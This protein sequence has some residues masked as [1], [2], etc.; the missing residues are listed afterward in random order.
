MTTR[1]RLQ[2]L[3]LAALLSPALVRDQAI[4]NSATYPG[5][6]AAP[7]FGSVVINPNG[8]APCAVGST[9][10]TLPVSGGVTGTV[11]IAPYIYTPTGWTSTGWIRCWKARGSSS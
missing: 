5:P 6:Q 10:C 4:P 11:S 1:K 8:G 7:T 3:L 2:W 9:G